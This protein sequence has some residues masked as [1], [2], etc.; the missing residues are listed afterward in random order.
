M[1]ML[2]NKLDGLGTWEECEQLRREVTE[3][4]RRIL[5]PHHPKTQLSLALLPVPLFVIG[6]HEEIASMY[7]E[8]LEASR[9]LAGPQST[10]TLETMN[11]LAWSLTLLGK[12][13]EAL[14]LAQQALTA[15]RQVLGAEHEDTLATQDTL[16]YVLE[17]LGRI[18]EARQLREQVLASYPK[19]FPREF[20]M[21]GLALNIAL[22]EGASADDRRRAIELARKSTELDPQDGNAW[23]ALGLTCAVSGRWREALN[24]FDSA[25]ERGYWHPLVPPS[26]I[27]RIRLSAD[28][29]EESYQPLL[30]FLQENRR[31]TPGSRSTEEED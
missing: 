21:H 31:K 24:A 17:G 18:E 26:I 25:V 6:K 22:T 10:F 30:G 2:A 8:L 20:F 7:E 28:I 5:G 29:N 23:R 19:N 9:Q 14:P 12:Y 27:Q 16:A 13:E 11:I 15:Q 1:Q 4:R 3:T